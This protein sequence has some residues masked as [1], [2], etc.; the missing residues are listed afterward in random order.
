MDIRTW[1]TTQTWVIWASLIDFYISQTEHVRSLQPSTANSHRKKILNFKNILFPLPEDGERVACQQKTFLLLSQMLMEK[2]HH[3]PV[4]SVGPSKER[5]FHSS[6]L[7]FLTGWC[8]CF[9][10][11]IWV[12]TSTQCQQDYKRGCKVELVNTAGIRRPWG[13]GGGLGTYTHPAA[14]RLS[15]EVQS[16][17]NLISVPLP[18]PGVSSAQWG[19][20]PPSHIVSVRQKEMVRGR[21]GWHLHP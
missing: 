9:P 19:T 12:S 2:P 21:S 10:A 20:E 15:E 3:L 8:Q 7:G 16:W 14:M 5:F 13:R 6:T 4:V 18:Y 17:A 1:G 11:G